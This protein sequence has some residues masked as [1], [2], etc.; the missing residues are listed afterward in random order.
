MT[1]KTVEFWYEFASTYSYLSVMRIEEA[2]KA[3]GLDVVWKPFLL[4]PIFNAQG[5]DNSPF[6]IYPAKGKYMWR[7]MERQCERYG[8]SFKKPDIFPVH[9]VTAAR[10]ALVGVEEG[11][12]PAFS[13]TLFQA[14]FADGQDISKADV[15]SDLMSSLGLDPDECLQR[16]RVP[17]TKE[18]L[19]MQ[20]AEASEKGVFG[21]PSFV[22]ADELF[23]GNDRMEEAIAFASRRT[24]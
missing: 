7:D 19:K 16:A 20:T 9:S 5:W 13:R 15:L 23:W 12:C 21:A 11:W 1:G 22:A 3:T 10:L 17:E 18:A 2:A 14:Q 6:N 24:S 4:G 8:L